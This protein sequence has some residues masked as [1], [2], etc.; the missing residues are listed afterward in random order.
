MNQKRYKTGAFTLIELLVVI[1]IIGILAG[2]LFPTVGIV[3]EKAKI[4]TSKARISQY[5]AAI[6][7]FKGEYS[8]YPFSTQLDGQGALDL[9]IA[10]NSLVFIETLSAREL[11]DP[12]KTVPKGGNR[13]RIQF[14]TFGEDEIADGFESSTLNTVVDGFGNNQIFIVFDHDNDGEVTVPDPEGGSTNTINIRSQLTAYVLADS[15]EGYPSYY[16]YE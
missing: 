4:A 2:I 9:S 6:Q 7:S 8:Y 5:L 3:R 13:R 1:A 14:Y 16:I 10:T 15:D 12:A 11:L